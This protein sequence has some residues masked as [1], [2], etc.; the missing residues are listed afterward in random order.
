MII[1]IAISYVYRVFVSDKLEHTLLQLIHCVH[2]ANHKFINIHVNVFYSTLGNYSECTPLQLINCV[3]DANRKY[4]SFHIII[5][6]VLTVSSEIV[7]R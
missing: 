6:K 7:K 2:D 4:N 1:G 5:C 3:Q